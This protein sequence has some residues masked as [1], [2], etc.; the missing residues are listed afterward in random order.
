[1][2]VCVCL[3]DRTQNTGYFTEQL[4]PCWKIYFPAENIYIAVLFNT[5]SVCFI[6]NKNSNTSALN[7]FFSPAISICNT[8]LSY[9]S[10]C[11]VCIKLF[12]SLLLPV[13]PSAASFKWLHTSKLHA[14]YPTSIWILR[15]SCL[16]TRLVDVTF[17]CSVLCLLHIKSCITENKYYCIRYLSDSYN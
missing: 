4:Y 14:K 15:S 17:A 7:F 11:A 8:F 2:C 9:D 12:Y 3:D 6:H 10:F 5:K 1:M 13:R 16:S